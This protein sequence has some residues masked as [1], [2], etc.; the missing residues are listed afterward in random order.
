M[1]NR[2]FTLIW[3]SQALSDVASEMTSLALPL[4]VLAATRSAV[5]AALVATVV[6]IAQLLAKLPSG[7]IADTYNRKRLMLLCDAAR[8]AVALLLACALATGNLTTIV[9]VGSAATI[10]LFSS[11][12]GPAESGVL[13]QAVPLERRR[14]AITRN[15]VRSNIAIAVGPPLGGMLLAAGAPMAF[16]ADACSYLLSLVLVARVA[17]THIPR[18]RAGAGKE[19]EAGTSEGTSA[20]SPAGA[21][22]GGGSGA[23]A[24]PAHPLRNT[25]TELTLGF[26]WVFRRS[27]LV[28]LIA[29]AAYVN[30]LGRSIELLAA[31]GVSHD[32]A[33]PVSAGL[34][35]TAAGIGGIA[36]GLCAGWI[37]KRL[38]P[39]TI[40]AAASVAWLLMMPCAS[41]GDELTSAVAVGL[42]V[43]SLPSVGS[44]VGLTISVEAPAHLQGRVGGAVTLLAIS[45]AWAGPGLTGFLIAA[46]GPLTASV[47]LAA[48]MVA[49]LIVLAASPRLRAAVGRIGTVAAPDPVPGP[50]AGPVA[51]PAPVV[52]PAPGSG[53]GSGSGPAPLPGAVPIP[54][55]PDTVEPEVTA[56]QDVMAHVEAVGAVL[57]AAAAPGE[58]GAG[59]GRPSPGADRR[60]VH[61]PDAFD[62]FTVLALGLGRARPLP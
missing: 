37:L 43:F 48:P 12:F 44:L 54:R 59:G 47:V 3:V 28:V 55:H 26:G 36:G 58:G 16:V 11:V 10:A 4:A 39:T 30:L 15:I 24:A 40:M 9:A 32:G 33:H 42:V 20:D 21:S 23:A 19:Q 57:A 29:F 38:R 25:A 17:Y 5:D 53:S 14:E 1:I 7:L 2:S 56:E 46:Q 62:P 31:F 18:P 27:G 50:A 13:R 34:V 8:A 35:L 52:D 49:P 51:E 45:I 22:T 60:S 41:T 6:G 61:L